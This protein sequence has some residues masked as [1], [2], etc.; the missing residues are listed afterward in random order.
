LQTPLA[1]LHDSVPRGKVS[2]LGGHGIGHSKKQK[3]YVRATYSEQYISIFGV[4]EDVQH[5]L[6]RSYNVIVNSHDGQ[7]M[8]HTDS[9]ASDSGAVRRE[10][11]TMM[12]AKIQT[13]VQ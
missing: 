5:F 13:T 7:L 1:S 9:H 6:K 4:C 11:R 3:V 8:L 12:D 2:I 10:G